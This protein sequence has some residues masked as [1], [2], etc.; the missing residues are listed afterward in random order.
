MKPFIPTPFVPPF[1]LSNPHVQTMLPK[2]IRQSTPNYQ[3]ELHSDSTGWASVAYDFVISHHDEGRPLAVMFHG[4][5]G[6]SQSHY[7][8]SFANHAKQLGINAVIVHY[9]GCGGV[10]NP[11]A[12]DYNAG[13]TKEIHYVLTQLAKRYPILWVVGVSLGGNLLA[14]YLGEYGD[15]AVCQVGVVVSAPVDLATSAKAMQKFVARH[16]YTPYLLKSLIKKALD[17]V[18]DEADKQTLAKLKKLEDFDDVYTAPRHGYGTGANYYKEASALPYLHA[19]VRPTL[20]ISSDDDPFLGEVASPADVSKNVQLLYS[21]H[22]GHVGF[23]GVSGS[24]VDL[25]WLARTTFEFF[26]WADSK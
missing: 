22:G 12:L 2:F 19:I 24:T 23:V 5:E 26:L 13:D 15:R 4:L 11:S 7:A 18:S 20:I 25:G 10:K 9:R 8:K 17:K 14:K 16:V 21:P 3:R 1:Y 6:S